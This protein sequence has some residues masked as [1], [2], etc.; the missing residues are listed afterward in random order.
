MPACSYIFLL[1]SSTV[2]GL[3]GAGQANPD[4]RALFAQLNDPRS[5]DR[6]ARMIPEVAKKDSAARN[7]AVSMLPGMINKSESNR[8]WKNA[9]RLAGQLRAVE[10]VPSLI[11][12]MGRGPIGPAAQTFTMH[13][14]LQD[15][16]V[17]QA[18][19]EIGDPAVSALADALRNGESKARRRVAWILLHIES[20]LARKALRDDLPTEK[21]PA[22][23]LWI[24]YRL[25]D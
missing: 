16:I 19:V 12:A 11:Q 18:L 25:R 5:T 13:E 17:G 15:D 24:Q 6:A 1:F 14:R 7:Y 3:S 9:V 8:V 10:V 20:P 4:I 21:D 23:V 2:F 22:I